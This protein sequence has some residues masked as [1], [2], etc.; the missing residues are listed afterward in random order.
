VF[1][2]IPRILLPNP[3]FSSDYSYMKFYRVT[4]MINLAGGREMGVG[5]VG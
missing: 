4:T 2:F 3:P 1:S 5:A